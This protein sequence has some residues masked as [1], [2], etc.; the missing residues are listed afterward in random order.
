MGKELWVCIG[1]PHPQHQR[2]MEK[3]YNQ[4]NLEVWEV[5]VVYDIIL[6]SLHII[7]KIIPTCPASLVLMTSKRSVRNCIK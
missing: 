4:R 3:L 1:R 2:L 5:G 7:I 6:M